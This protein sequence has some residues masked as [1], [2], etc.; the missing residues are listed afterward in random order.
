MAKAGNEGRLY[1]SVGIPE[2]CAALEAAGHEV[3]KREVRLASGPLRNLGRHI[4]EIDLHADIAVPVA[5]VITGP[6]TGQGS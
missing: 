3:A 1:G 2:I 4:V 6:Q 5:V